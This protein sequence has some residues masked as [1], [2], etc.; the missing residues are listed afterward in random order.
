MTAWFNG[1]TFLVAAVTAWCMVKSL[2]AWAAHFRL[3]DIPNLRSSHTIPTPR[4]G[5]LAIVLVTL[6]GCA[7]F[8]QVTGELAA[9]WFVLYVTGAAIIAGISLL[10]DLHGL[11]SLA[12]L[13]VHVAVATAVVLWSEPWTSGSLGAVAPPAIVAAGLVIWI[14]GLTNAYNFMDGIDGIAGVQTVVASLGWYVLGMLAGMPHVALLGVL[15]GASALGF[16]AHNWPPA[17]IFMGDVGSAFVGF[18]L[19]YLAVEAGKQDPFLLVAGVLLVWP[20]VADAAFTFF[21]RL[22]RRENVL[23]AHRSH[24]YQRLVISGWSHRN[25]TLLYGGLASL[26]VGLALSVLC[27]RL[28]GVASATAIVA[29]MFWGLWA[30]V[31]RSERV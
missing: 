22:L 9:L 13:A 21:R 24:L 30:I 31:V 12:R 18:S 28:P 15:L 20:F 26:G 7:V 14:V 11:S 27:A 2:R 5:G 16:L 6:A 10:D 23:T 19:A 8:A 3:I 1:L 29:I 4:G 17:K 25:V